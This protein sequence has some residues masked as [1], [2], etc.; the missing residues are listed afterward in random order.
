M[1]KAIAFAGGVLLFAA[2]QAILFRVAIPVPAI[3]SGGWFL[4]TGTGAASVAASFLV[5]G[6]VIGLSRRNGILD[7]MFAAL[8]GVVAMTAILFWLGPGNIF[9]IVVIFGTF[10]IGC[11]TC[12]GLAISTIA[13][14]SR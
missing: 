9:P 10:V 11:S 2:V 1:S 8:G 12:F 6:A 3:K 13:G 14:G 5:L 7:A 4:N